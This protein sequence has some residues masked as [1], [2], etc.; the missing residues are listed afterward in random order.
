MMV[1]ENRVLRRIFGPK[2]DDVT[3]E[4][5]KLHNEELLTKYYAGDKIE[6]NEVGG[7]CSTYGENRSVY[8]ILVEITEEKRQPGRPRSRYKDNI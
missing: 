6:K 3:R 7:E 8:R 2:R 5:R 4:W 1:S